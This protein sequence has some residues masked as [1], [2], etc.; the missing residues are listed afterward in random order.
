MQTFDRSPR[1]AR[2]LETLSSALAS[3]RGLPVLIGILLIVIA[4]V[5]QIIA[6][7]APSPALQCIWAITL[8]VGLLSALIGIVMSEPLGR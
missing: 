2:L 3:R 5:A 8:H 4:F 1:I 7:F 6:W